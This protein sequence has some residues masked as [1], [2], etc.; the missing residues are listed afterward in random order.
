MPSRMSSLIAGRTDTAMPQDTSNPSPPGA[1][2]AAPARSG[3]V[4]GGLAVKAAI[5]AIAAGITAVLLLDW[6]VWGAGKGRQVT[7]DAYVRGDITPL[8]AKVPGYVR[9]VL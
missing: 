2:E 8:S 4:P 7:D 3:R 6:D 9:R 5:L 1:T